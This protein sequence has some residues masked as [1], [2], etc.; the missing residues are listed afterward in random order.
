MIQKFVDKVSWFEIGSG[1][2]P[3]KGV[4]YFGKTAL[5]PDLLEIYANKDEQYILKMVKSKNDLFQ[6]AVNEKFHYPDY[7]QNFIHTMNK[8]VQYSEEWDYSEVV[9]NKQYKAI[10]EQIYEDVY[11][12]FDFL[13][14]TRK[15]DIQLHP[16]MEFISPGELWL[17]INSFVL[18]STKTVIDNYTLLQEMKSFIES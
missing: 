13:N 10:S 1:E 4:T 8:I 6:I 11:N 15:V 9:M 16:D 12:A 2:N 18:S 5:N 7:G 3:I 17:A 14:W